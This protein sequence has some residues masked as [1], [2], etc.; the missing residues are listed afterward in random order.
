MKDG[1]MAKNIN[2]IKER[3]VGSKKSL[4]VTS[5]GI[6][7]VRDLASFLASSIE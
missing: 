7:R 5:F 3:F 1:G 6:K 2:E 4:G